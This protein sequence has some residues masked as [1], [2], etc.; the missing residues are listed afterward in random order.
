MQDKLEIFPQ[1]CPPELANLGIDCTCPFDI[2]SQTS[3][4]EILE[5]DIP[6][7]ATTIL[8]FYANG[9]FDVKVTISNA[10]NQHVACF[11]FLYTMMKA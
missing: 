2:P 10:S 4:D 7:L 3:F 9:D 11:R 8:S 1:N 6:D 5:Y